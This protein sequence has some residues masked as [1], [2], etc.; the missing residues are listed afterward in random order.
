M[1]QL[2]IIGNLVRDPESRTTQ[3]G[4]QVV[5]F[6]VAVNRRND[7]EK[8]DFFRVNAWGEMGRVCH[9]Y[10]SKGRKVAVTGTVSAEAYKTNDGAIKASMDVFAEHVEFLSPIDKTQQNAPQGQKT[11][12]QSGFVQ[13]EEELPF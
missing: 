12:A 5:T 11:D 3:S 7:K 8:A 9:Q 10:L 4:K 2:N 6:T 13:V 1:N